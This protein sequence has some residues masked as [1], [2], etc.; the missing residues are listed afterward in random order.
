MEYV[1]FATHRS[2][3]Y[4]SWLCRLDW[5]FVAQ[6]HSVFRWLCYIV[7]AWIHSVWL[8]AMTLVYDCHQSVIWAWECL[9]RNWYTWYSVDAWMFAGLWLDVLLVLDT[10]I[11][12]TKSFDCHWFHSP[13]LGGILLSTFLVIKMILWSCHDNGRS[14]SSLRKFSWRRLHLSFSQN[15]IL[16][17]VRRLHIYSPARILNSHRLHSAWLRTSHTVLKVRV[18]TCF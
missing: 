2:T 10:H 11:Q 6:I 18:R 17:I 3:V 16:K 14:N 15:H 13:T 12:L 8:V 5:K 7:T 1:L 4:V 9:P